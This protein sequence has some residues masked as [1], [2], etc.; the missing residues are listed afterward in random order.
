MSLLLLFAGAGIQAPPPPPPPVPLPSPT[1]HAIRRVRRLP[2]L[3]PNQ[4]RQFFQ[5]FQLD[6]ETGVGLGRGQG[7]D[8]LVCLRWSDD[9]GYTWSHEH[10]VSAG[11]MGEYSRRAIWRRLGHSRDR[12]FE[13]SVS[14]PVAWRILDAYLDVT[15]G[16]S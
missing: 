11:E 4:V 8:P 5:R 3:S 6:V 13:V 9:G 12:V 16:S 2:H 10:W 15:L 1:F 7:A 14:D